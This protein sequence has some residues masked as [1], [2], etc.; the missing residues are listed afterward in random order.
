MEDEISGTR[1]TPRR[2]APRRKTGAP[3]SAAGKNVGTGGPV[4]GDLKSDARARERQPSRDSRVQTEAAFMNDAEGE[5]VERAFDERLTSASSV[6]DLERL[7]SE[8][9][10]TAV[11]GALAVGFLIGF[12][13]GFLAARD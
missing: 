13:V 6:R 2:R 8:N 3:R 11:M 10:R 4:E 12:G 1:P 7:A 5:P 9:P